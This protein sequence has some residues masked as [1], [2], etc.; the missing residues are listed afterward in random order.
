[1]KTRLTITIAVLLAWLGAGVAKAQDYSKYVWEFPQ[2]S[3]IKLPADKQWMVDDLRAEVN[4]VLQAGHL[5]PYYYNSADLHHEGYF[6]YVAP[7]RIITTLAWAYPHL[8]PEQQGKVKQYVAK[9]LAEKKYAPWGGKALPAA[10]GAGREG[11]EK[12]KGFNFDRW[13]GMEG[14]YRPYMHTYY[15]LWLYGY[16]TGDWETIKSH[17]ADIK[18][19]YVSNAKNAELYGDFG[20]HIAMARLARQFGDEAVENGALDL[21]NKSFDAGKDYAAMEK[22]SFKYFNRLKEQRHNVLGSTQFMLLSMSPEVGRYLKDNVK[23]AVVKK[24]SSMEKGY[25]HWWII[26]PP[27]GTWAG[28]I[29]PDCE[30]NG[31]P[32]EIFGMIFPVERWVAD[33]DANK[34][35]GY[36]ASGPDGLGDSYWLEPLVWTIEAY[37]TTTWTDVRPAAK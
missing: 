17:W 10:E 22:L 29:G 6:L 37:G 5:A 21:A 18:S 28:N 26:S 14:Q 16:R 24:N 8:S 19:Y 9:E 20:A 34:L 4:K 2:A 11:Y 31:L 25:P 35:A 36:M 15:G 27:Y 12:P 30:G 33:A 23:D 1:M 13:M 3:Q 32:R 7:G